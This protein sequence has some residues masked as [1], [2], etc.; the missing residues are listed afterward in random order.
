MQKYDSPHSLPA[1]APRPLLVAN[2]ELDP[3]CPLEGLEEP[4]K[5]TKA[6]YA[7]AGVPHNF[8]AYIE[9]GLDHV[10]SHGLDGEV[11]AWLEQYLLPH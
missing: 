3:R 6:A 4:F 9:E 1:L 10:P 2:G 5:R 8:K 7:A 11:N